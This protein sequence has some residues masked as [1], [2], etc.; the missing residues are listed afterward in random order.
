MQIR[1]ERMAYGGDAIGKLDDGRTA[2]VRGG[3][4]GDLVEARMDAEHPR[5][6][7]LTATEI[8]EASEQRVTPPCPYFGVCGGC[9]WQHISYDAQTEAKSSAVRDALKRIGHQDVPVNECLPS[10]HEYGYRNKIELVTQAGS[11][12][13]TVGYM[14]AGTNDLVRVDSCLLLPH[15]ARNLPKALAGSLRYLSGSSDLGLVRVGARVAAHTTDLEIA[16]WTTPGPFPR[17]MA[18]EAVGQATKASG[19]IRVLARDDAGERSIKGVEVLRGN[20]AWREQFLGVDMLISAPSFFQVNTLTAERLV[21]TAIEAL[22][23]DGTDR[24]LDLYSGAGTFT[25]PLSEVAGEVVAVEQSGTALSD[26]RRNLERAGTWAEVAPG[27]AQRALPDL[28]H[29]DLALVDPP[30]SGMRPGA[31]AALAGTG[32]RRIVYVSCDP[33][34]LAR[35]CTG[36]SELGYRL[37]EATPVDLFPQT[38]HVETIA[39]LDREVD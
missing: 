32:A 1:I 4:P 33:S 36:L 22:G 6:A 14:R 12:G 2:F 11:D 21:S 3:C 38:Y 10:E 24:V 25:L 18:G 17:K 27:D 29:F 16:M 26:L 37:I 15:R 13:L 30:R 23:A 39:V 31:L 5:Y 35:D 28:G 8:I 34:T 20:G 9:Q 7:N 19:V